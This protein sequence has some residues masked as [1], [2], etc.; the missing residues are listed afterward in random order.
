MSQEDA[1]DFIIVG[2]G[3]SGGIAA[4]VLQS[5]GARCLMLESGVHYTKQDFPFREADYTPRLYWGGGLEYNTRCN[6]GFLRGRC[7]G[8]GSIVNGALMDRFDHVAFDDWRAE[9]GVAF[10]NED[11]MAPHY[12]AA[13]SQM[14]LETIR[15]EHRNNNALLFIKGMENLGH[16][17]KPLRRCQ[18]DCATDQGN[19][20]IACLGGC[21]RDSKQSTLVTAIPRAIAAGMRLESECHVDSIVSTADG[22]TVNARQHGAE[23]SFHA[24]RILLAAGALGT[25]QIL[26]RSGFAESLPALGRGFAMHPQFMTL[27]LFDEPVDAHKG[28]LQGAKSLDDGFRKRGFKLENVFAPPIS[29]AVLYQKVGPELQQLLQQYRHM[30]C[31][32]V[33]VRDENTGVVRVNRQGR[34]QI[35]KNLTDQDRRRAGDGRQVVKDLF[36]SLAP[37]RVVQCDWPF[38]LHLMGGCAMGND[39]VRS[40]VAP[41]FTVHDHPNI[42]IADSSVFPNAP[43]INPALTVM[44]L[45]HRMAAAAARN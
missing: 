39:A 32:E 43:G 25:T 34:L 3:S 21:H 13:E 33:A 42:L 18:S 41:D 37:K 6:I 45:A 23:R 28:V 29:I 9:S 5:A 7:V 12:D 26:L 20:C 22:V 4:Q 19:D 38:G 15:D 44:A 16:T 40:V 14:V 11:D 35:E 2:S 8:G 27:A 31:I 1:F 30:A 10:L 17:W 24:P 36:E